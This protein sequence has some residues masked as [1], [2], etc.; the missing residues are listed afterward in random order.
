MHPL[1][2]DT[3]QN[4]KEFSIWGNFVY[5]CKKQLMD[6]RLFDYFTEKFED[7]LSKTKSF[8]EAFEKTNNDLGFVA[9]S[10]YK[11]FSI[12]RSRKRKRG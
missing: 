9:Y 11:S 2:K 10:S 4:G 12:V 5:I 8:T 1:L 6:K 3:S 7:N